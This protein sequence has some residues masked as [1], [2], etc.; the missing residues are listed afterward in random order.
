MPLRKWVWLINEE[1][2]SCF[3]SIWMSLLK[4]QSVLIVIFVAEL[5]VIIT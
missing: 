2:C 5:L 3:L 4:M 1:P